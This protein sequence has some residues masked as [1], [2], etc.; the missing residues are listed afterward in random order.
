MFLYRD[1][2]GRLNDSME[3]LQI[4]KDFSELETYLHKQFGPG[5]VTVKPYC[6]DERICWDT[7]IVCHDGRAVGFTNADTQP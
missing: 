2:R 6:Y 1:H 3:T 4:M 5:E 7:Q